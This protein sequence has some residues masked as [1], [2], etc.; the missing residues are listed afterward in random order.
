[1][2]TRETACDLARDGTRD[3][4]RRGGRGGRPR[5]DE[6]TGH[7][8]PRRPRHARGDGGRALPERPG[9]DLRRAAL[10]HPRAVRR[11]RERPPRGVPR[12]ARDPQHRRRLVGGRLRP[13]PRRA[14][15]SATRSTTATRAPSAASQPC[16]SGCRTPSSTR[17]TG[18]SSSRS[19]RCTSSPPNRADL[20]A[21][22]DSALLIPDLF[23]FWLTGAGPRRA[24]ERVHDRPAARGRRLGRR[25]HRRARACRAASCPRS[26]LRASG[27]APCGPRSPRRSARAPTS[28]SPRS[29]RTTRPRPCV[30]VPMRP[31]AAA[32]ISCGTWGLVGVEVER[33]V[34]TA[35][36]L[37]ANFTNEGGVG[38]PRPAPAQHHG[39][40][41]AQRGG[42]HVGARRAPD[43]PAD[44]A[45]LRRGGHR[46]GSGLRRERP[47]LPSARRHAEPHRRVVH[48][49][50]PRT[51]AHARRVRAQHRGVARAGLRGCRARGRP[52]RRRRRA[53]DPHRRRRLAQRAALPAHRRPLR[54]CPCSP[55]PSRRRRSATC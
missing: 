13:A 39:A 24:D 49:A 40:V 37:A 29:A 17:A 44:A 52:H 43:R 20:L 10:E 35:E 4:R 14:G 51:A 38:R 3:E 32:Y 36:A 30:A 31:D 48:R 1:M 47:A 50:R 45:R 55:A 42:A 21:F 12:R 18:C 16:T 6:R 33:P 2:R 8:R 11:R 5:R 34:L 15:C 46:P 53:H 26:S 28:R 19:T 7:G 23:G 9:A 54:G 22:A 27:S 41:G 25:A